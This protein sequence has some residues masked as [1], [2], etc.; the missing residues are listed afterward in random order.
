[1]KFVKTY[2][3]NENTLIGG[4]RGGRVEVRREGIIGGNMEKKYILINI[5][6]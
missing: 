2:I 6:L 3:S 4:E 5:F 1:M